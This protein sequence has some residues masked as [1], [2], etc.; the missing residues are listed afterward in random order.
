MKRT[1]IYLLFSTFLI[2]ASYAKLETV[3]K[4]IHDKDTKAWVG[5]CFQLDSETLGKNYLAKVDKELCRPK[6]TVIW[7]N[8]KNGRCYERDSNPGFVYAKSID[9]QHCKPK[10]TKYIF[11]SFNDRKGCYETD[12]KTS[13]LEFFEKRDDKN[14]DSIELEYKFLLGKY[15]TGKCFNLNKKQVPT[16][17][18][19]KF[20]KPKTTIYVF[21][22]VSDFKGQ[23]FEQSK[24]GEKFYTKKVSIENCRPIDTIFIFYTD[25]NPSKSKCYELDE[26][27]KGN[28]YL[29][30]V[31]TKKCL[32]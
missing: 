27:T 8:T 12:I 21:H 29:A 22:R 7:F 17:V 14:C 25:K 23:C 5:N 20:C 19:I 32:N 31:K 6:S 15:H 10:R 30:K 26:K 3:Y 9:R 4:W 24:L 13:G 2:S 28:E 11:T 1:I 18:K 16:Q